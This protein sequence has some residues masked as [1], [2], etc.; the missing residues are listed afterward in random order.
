MKANKIKKE[1]VEKI[2]IEILHFTKSTVLLISLLKL[3]NFKA[4]F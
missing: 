1:M 4:N 3:T 2:S